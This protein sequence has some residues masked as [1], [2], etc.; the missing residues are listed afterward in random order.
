[1]LDR[2]LYEIYRI[3]LI[4]GFIALIILYIVGVVHCWFNGLMAGI[5]IHLCAG[6][7]SDIDD[8]DL[9]GDEWQEQLTETTDT[10]TE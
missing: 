6:S 3:T 2:Y 9:F 5:R 4:I 10:D 8:E 1:M 7:Q